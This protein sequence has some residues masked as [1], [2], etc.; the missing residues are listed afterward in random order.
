MQKYNPYEGLE[1]IKAP[2]HFER[3]VL[4]LLHQRQKKRVRSRTLR[5]SFAGAM[6]A[7]AVVFIVLNLFIIP[8]KG[9]VEFSD[10]ERGIP[11]AFERGVTSSAEQTIPII[12]AVD[13]TE[14]IRRSR[15]D[16][17][18]IYIL[19]QCSD[20]TSRGIKY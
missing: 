6:G 14:E 7:I 15:Q 19:E 4:N 13:Y 9:T 8:E 18:T 1:R 10:L 3:D 16:P 2:A 5:L 12:E 17:P 20:E 11:P